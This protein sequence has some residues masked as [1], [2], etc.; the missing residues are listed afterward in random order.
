MGLLTLGVSIFYPFL[1]GMSRISFQ[2]S[3]FVVY[4]KKEQ[5]GGLL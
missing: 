2:T 5:I 1:G 4:Y 3:Y